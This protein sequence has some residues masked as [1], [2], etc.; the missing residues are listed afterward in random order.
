MK[1]FHSI[2]AFIS[3]AT[4]VALNAIFSA[5]ATCQ[6]KCLGIARK[7]GGAASRVFLDACELVAQGHAAVYRVVIMFVAARSFA[8]RIARRERMQVTASWRLV[9]SV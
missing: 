2:F 1:R 3:L 8:Q 7:L 5:V 6:A 9:P 4:F